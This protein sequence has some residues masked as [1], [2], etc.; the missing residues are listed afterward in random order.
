M[1]RSVHL[2]SLNRRFISRRLRLFFNGCW[3]LFAEATTSDVVFDLYNIF[4]PKTS[5]GIVNHFTFPGSRSILK[6]ECLIQ[7]GFLTF[8]VTLAGSIRNR[9][10]CSFDIFFCAFLLFLKSTTNAPLS[11]PCSGHCVQCCF[12]L[13]LPVSFF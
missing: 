10:I 11:F 2:F 6:L 7:L 9:V 5:K 13:A 12:T 4:K 8:E 3:P 1:T